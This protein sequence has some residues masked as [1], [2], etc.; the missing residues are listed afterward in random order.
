[1]SSSTTVACYW[2]PLI[3]LSLQPIK[4]LCTFL[5]A[6]TSLF[7][8]SPVL[9]SPS[10]N[11][12]ASTGEALAAV[13]V[14]RVSPI[15]VLWS[16]ALLQVSSPGLLAWW[17]CQG[18][19]ERISTASAAHHKETW[20]FMRCFHLKP[21]T[22]TWRW[23]YRKIHGINRLTSSSL[24]LGVSIATE[25]VIIALIRCKDGKLMKGF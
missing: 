18:R 3:S 25:D 14:G 2:T 9:V 4:C 6:S 19:D 16:L 17:W 20:L 21:Q 10:F 5:R 8:Q 15:C 24:E 23:H 7:N 11:H 1:M 12:K 13:V 22:S